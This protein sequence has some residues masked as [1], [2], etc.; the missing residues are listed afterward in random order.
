MAFQYDSNPQYT[1]LLGGDYIVTT[2]RLTNTLYTFDG[3]SWASVLNLSMQARAYHAMAFDEKRKLT[4]MFG[5]STSEDCGSPDNVTLEFNGTTAVAKFPQIKPDARCFHTMAYDASGQQ[6]LLFG[7]GT[8]LFTQFGDTWAYQQLGIGCTSNSQCITGYCVDG[9]CCDTPCDQPCQRCNGSTDTGKCVSITTQGTEDPG[10]CEGDHACR[11]DG[12]CRLKLGYSCSATDDCL[13]RLCSDGVCCDKVCD[14]AC[15]ACIAA[16][17]APANGTCGTASRGDPGAPVCAAYACDG[18]NAT[19]PNPASATCQSDVDCAADYFC[20]VAGTCLARKTQA[21]PCNEATEC[22]GGDCRICSDALLCVDGYCC[23]SACDGECNSCAFAGHLG[24]CTNA[25]AGY[26]GNPPCP[27]AACNGGA[28]CPG[29]ACTTDTNCNAGY[30]CAAGGTCR[31]QKVISDACDLAADCAEPGCRVCASGTCIDGRCCNEACG[32]P[33]ASCAVTPGTCGSAPDGATPR[34]TICGAYLCSGTARACAVSCSGDADCTADSYCSSAHQCV[35]RKAQGT[36]CGSTSANPCLEAG[37]RECVTGKSCVDGF[38]CNSAC[39]GSCDTCAGAVPGTCAPMTLGATG[40]PS[41]TP[42][43]CNGASTACPNSCSLNSQCASG[44]HCASGACVQN[45]PDGSPCSSGPECVHG[46]CVDGVCCDTACN[47]ACDQ[48]NLSGAAGTCSTSPKGTFASGCAYLCDGAK[49]SCPTSCAADSD[50]ATGMYCNDANQCVTRK[51][52][53]AACSLINGCVAGGCQMCASGHCVDGVCCDTTCA[54]A[55]D[56]CNLAGKEGTCSPV[57]AGDPGTPACQGANCDGASPSCPGT[58]CTADANCATGFYC[59]AGGTCQPVKDQGS[60]CDTTADCNVAGCRVCGTRPCVDGYCCSGACGASC[61]RCDV[62][63]GT[64]ATAPAGSTPNPTCG[65]YL[66]N[67]ASPSCPATC[68]SDYDC[69]PE[70]FCDATDHCTSRKDQGQTCGVSA[71]IACQQ[72][73]CRECKSGLSCVD[74]YCCDSPCAGRCDSCS[75]NPGTCTVL[76][77]G[78]PGQPACNGYYCDGAGPD[79]PLDCASNLDCTAGYHCETGLCK[80]DKPEGALCSLPTECSSGN[81]VDGYCCDSLCNG[82]CEACNLNAGVCT[83]VPAGSQP[84]P[85]CGS[86]VCSGT[87]GSCPTGCAGDSD[88]GSDGY[89]NKNNQCVSRKAAGMSCGTQANDCLLAGCRECASGSCADGYCCD[90]ACEGKCDSCALVPGT[91]TIVGQGEQGDPSCGAYLCDGVSANCPVSCTLNTQCEQDFYCNSGVCVVKKAAKQPCTAP[92]ECKTGACA[93]GLCCDRDCL[94]QCEACDIAGKEGMCS[95]VT[96]LPHGTTRS[97]CAGAGTDCEGSCNGVDLTCRYPDNTKKCG[98]TTCANDVLQP[99]VCNSQGACVD[100]DK[101]PCSPYSCDTAA[102]TCKSSCTTSADCAAGA[103]CN[104]QTGTCA[105][106]GGTCL[107]DFAVENSDG[108]TT[109]CAP[110]RCKAGVCQDACTAA[111]DCAEGYECHAPLCV[112]VASDGG[113]GGGGS[114]GGTPSGEPPVSATSN[115]G[116]GCQIGQKTSFRDGMGILGLIG[117]AVL[118]QRR[119]RAIGHVEARH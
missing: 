59:A 32:E 66:C 69:G 83:P 113:T 34:T 22:K 21:Q 89:C 101:L 107:D 50:C 43:L 8:D 35:A 80:A 98:A 45:K 30:Y 96:G 110:Y 40:Q 88:C 11:N 53:G 51:S 31:L 36:Q 24:T 117:L 68:T 103:E 25:D 10:S 47:G 1:L 17:G 58:A 115:S 64:C 48:C 81:C 108:T 56:A 102:Q 15:D 5:G 28:T 87:T 92:Q 116:C 44:Y 55:C 119:R 42:Y 18:A 86:F 73:G 37:C 77:D 76:P 85:S 104:T 75:V 26:A 14:Q 13:S 41:C 54:N 33:C 106:S 79:C 16:R 57:P 4:V 91:C 9:V 95:L 12:L 62:T 49:T 84:V 71:A 60:S 20:S 97:P 6:V 61:D 29:D 78:S 94:G 70:A 63:P 99:Q 93:D 114:D 27:G 111:N 74:G 90:T 100:G 105:A 118:S 7:G 52:N 82:P 2:P 46:Y 39:T 72:P 23:N 109:S 38:C 67:G 3:A 112:R 19:C 65:N